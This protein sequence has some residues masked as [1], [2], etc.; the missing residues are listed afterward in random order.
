MYNGKSF[1]IESSKI[2]DGIKSVFYSSSFSDIKAEISSVFSRLSTV[3]TLG[4]SKKASQPVGTTT[5]SYACPES[6][7]AWSEWS[8]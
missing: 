4:I 5:Y 7:C 8:P 6:P 3:V 2:I 1:N